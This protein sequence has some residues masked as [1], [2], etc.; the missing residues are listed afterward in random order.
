MTESLTFTAYCDLVLVR[1]YEAE[2]EADRNPGAPR[3]IDVAS[4]MADI[5][6]QGVPEDWA[7]DAAAWIINQGYANDYLTDA[8]AT[9]S[10]SPE[11]RIYVEAPER[12]TGIIGRYHQGSQFVVIHGDSNQVSVG[13]GQTVTQTIGE[14]SKEEVEELLD[15]AESR[16]QADATLTDSARQDALAD[17]DSIRTQVAKAAPN[18]NVLAALAT[19]LGSVASLTDIADK[20]RHLFS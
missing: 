18:R 7:W 19:T 5:T 3:V 17:I 10:L 4:L 14:F 20:L 15:Q 11:G 16:L 9:T 6:E 8:S 12:G 13:H 2:R 1:L